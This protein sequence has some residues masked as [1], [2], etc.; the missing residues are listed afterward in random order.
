MILDINK[1]RELSKS[2][3]S[4]HLSSHKKKLINYLNQRIYRMASTGCFYLTV[5]VSEVYEVKDSIE[6]VRNEFT[7]AGYDFS[8][9]E[10][11]ISIGWSE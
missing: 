11:T 8:V 7:K 1:M 3:D 10:E 6:E 4:F 2:R 5:P 9:D